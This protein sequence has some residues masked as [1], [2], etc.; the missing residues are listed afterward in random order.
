VAAAIELTGARATKFAFEAAAP[1]Q[2]V[3]HLATHGFFLG[4]RC[5]SASGTR[6][7]GLMGEPGGGASAVMSGDNPLLLSGLALAGANRRESVGTGGDDGILTAEE[8]SALDLSGTEWAVLSACETGVGEVRSGEG[9]LGLRR[10]F[11]VAG[12]RTLIMSLWEVEDTS[13]RQ[14]MR[15]L[16]EARLERG[17]GTAEAV[18]EANLA[19]LDERRRRRQSTHPFFWGGFVAAGDWR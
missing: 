6:G 13:A 2:R 4:D 3:L 12:A 14:W 18:R 1:R 10:A 5:E 8:I 17:A 9:V 11:Q 15:S 16:Y 7:I 19:M